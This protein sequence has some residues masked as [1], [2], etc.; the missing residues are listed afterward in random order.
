MSAAT[1]A[2]P[3]ESPNNQ[4]DSIGRLMVLADAPLD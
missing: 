3:A 2:K 1:Y 4:N